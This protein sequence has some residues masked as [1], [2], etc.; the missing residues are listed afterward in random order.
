[1][2]EWNEFVRWNEKKKI[3]VW[4]LHF[5]HFI[6]QKIK[7]N[8]LLC[9]AFS[10]KFFSFGKFIRFKIFVSENQF[11]LR[12][13]SKMNISLWLWWFEFFT[14]INRNTK[15]KNQFW[16]TMTIVFFFFESKDWKFLTIVFFFQSFS[17][18]KERIVFELEKDKDSF[19]ELYYRFSL[20]ISQ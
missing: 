13:I 14:E 12:S 5:H 2:N 7:S 11:P 10:F 16:K 8:S 17:M 19:T 15:H 20:K 9:F 3:K 18:R 1:M 4:I 6:L